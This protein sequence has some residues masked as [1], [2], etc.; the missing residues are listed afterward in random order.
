MRLSD[1][2]SCPA[3]EFSDGSR[4]QPVAAGEGRLRCMAC[5][6][7]W[8]EAGASAQPGDLY[9]EVAGSMSMANAQPAPNTQSGWRMPDAFVWLSAGLAVFFLVAQPFSLF[10]PSGL[11]SIAP[12]RSKPVEISAL[13]A[14]QHVRDGQFAVRVEGRITNRTRNRQP[15]GEVDVVL[16]GDGGGRVYGWTHRPAVPWL[17]PGQSIRFTTANGNVPRAA[18]KVV[19]H[20]AGVS[21]SAQL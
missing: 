17:E 20:S 12:W 16:T 1:S 18:N 19:I 13:S 7:E 5:G 9:G 4:G 15:I 8:R 2:I 14:R 21:A 10:G 11:A 6:G 3:C